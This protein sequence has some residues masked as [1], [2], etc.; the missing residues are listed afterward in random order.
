MFLKESMEMGWLIFSIIPFII[1]MVLMYIPLPGLIHAYMP[2][3]MMIIATVAVLGPGIPFFACAYESIK[4]RCATM[5]VLISIGVLSAYA[6]GCLASQDIFDVSGHAFFMTA[7][8]LITF[9]HIGEYMEE[10]VKKRADKVLRKFL[11]L[12]THRAQVFSI[13]NKVYMDKAHFRHFVDKVTHTF[14]PIAVGLSIATFFCWYFLF[15]S[16]AGEH[17][18]LWALKMAIAVLVIS[19]PCSLC[20]AAPT[21]TMAASRVG[22]R[23][24]ILIKQT[25]V[26]EKAAQLNVLVFDMDKT[27]HDIRDAVKLLRRMNIRVV[28]MT[29]DREQAARFVAS[30]IDIDEYHV[31]VSSLEKRE[32]IKA[33]QKQGMR[34][35]VVNSGVC[36]ISTMAQADV[37]IVLGTDMDISKETGDIII[38]GDDM[39]DV[40]KSIQLGRITL[41]K[42]KQNV[43]W[44]F[45]FNVIGISIAAGV[46]YPS[47]GI[48]LKSEHAELAMVLSSFLVVINSLLLKRAFFHY[49][50]YLIHTESS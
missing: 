8:M 27:K 11:E 6:Y 50:H 13:E 16:L 19:T 25:S 40:V 22:L 31:R 43:F 12:N 7:V 20:W 5:C 32:I 1:M 39:T 21:A 47:F 29:E 28:V 44:A 35:G 23:H 48:S 30:G 38:I 45:L 24:S 33:F 49:G 18:F 9:S 15:Y 4:N 42:I 36:D 46:L 14:T 2:Q 3:I 37:G 34:V 17:Y 41:L 10:R 26:L